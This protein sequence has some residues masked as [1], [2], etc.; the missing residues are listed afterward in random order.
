MIN[1]IPTRQLTLL[2]Q[3]DMLFILP[4]IYLQ[5]YHFPRK[6]QAGFFHAMTY[7]LLCLL[8]LKD[9]HRLKFVHKPDLIIKLF[10]V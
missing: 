9:S 10:I 6:I 3:N 1:M 4:P 5:H 2:N 8:I 7:V